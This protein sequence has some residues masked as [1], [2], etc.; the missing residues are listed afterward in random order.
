M[1]LFFQ[2]L[3]RRLRV[4]IHEEGVGNLGNLKL[5]SSV[6]LRTSAVDQMENFKQKCR[7]LPQ[8]LPGDYDRQDRVPDGRDQM[9]REPW[10]WPPSPADRLP[11]ARLVLG[12]LF[13]AFFFLGF[14]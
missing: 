13:L 14:L 7:T 9:P 12:F 6:S 3:W 5:F 2:H 8:P 4:P 11:V 1:L 10:R